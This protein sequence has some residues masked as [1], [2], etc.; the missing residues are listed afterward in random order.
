MKTTGLM[1]FVLIAFAFSLFQG[2]ASVAMAPTGQDATSKTF[3]APTGDQA[4]LYVYRNSF[5]GAALKKSLYLDG[6]YLGET[7]NMVFFHILISPG[8]HKLSTESEFS[9][10]A[11]T[12]SAVAGI[13]YFFRQYIKMGVFVGGAN[14]EQVSEEVGQVEV[15]KCTEAL[16]A[17]VLTPQPSTTST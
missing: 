13:N 4:G 15:L 6:A 10:N 1:K 3:A 17:I 12:F 8:E 5:V 7:A 9:E 16:G 2:C 14:L 11:L